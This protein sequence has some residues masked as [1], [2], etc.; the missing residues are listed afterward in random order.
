MVGA[1]VVS[2]TLVGR[3]D[4]T[5]TVGPAALSLPEIELP[6]DVRRHQ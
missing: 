5:S 2:G 3:P 6:Q 1:F 4:R